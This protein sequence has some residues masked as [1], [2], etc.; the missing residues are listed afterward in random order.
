MNIVDYVILGII[1]LSVLWGFYRGF[2]QSVLNLGGCLL[3][4]LGAFYLYPTI[5]NLIQNDHELLRS[6]LHYTDASSRI[7]D[8]ELS[9][10]N[11]LSLPQ[12]AISTVL[13]KAALPPP[14]DTILRYNIEG[15]VFA[16]VGASTVSDYVSQTILSVSINVLCFV[17]CFAVLFIVISIL[18]NMLRAVF[19]F[20]VLKH[21]DWLIG[22][23]FGVVR[24]IVICY[25][26]FAVVPLVSTIVQIDMIDEI[27]SASSLAEMFTSGNLILSIMNRRL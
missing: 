5:A 17:A 12:E 21:L 2:I 15:Q 18:L 19:Q 13:E 3:A 6:L 24:G 14:F 26:L 11:I 23:A 10:T 8:L 4:F 25:A 20:P 7:G 1:A 22:G 16:P 9:L 27:I